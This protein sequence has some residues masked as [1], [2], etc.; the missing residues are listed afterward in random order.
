MS[1]SSVTATI[2]GSSIYANQQLLGLYELDGGDNIV[3]DSSGTI[4]TTQDPSFT[5]LTVGGDASFNGNTEFLGDISA[6]DISCANVYADGAMN[7]TGIV[8]AGSFVGD[9]TGDVT[10]NVTGNADTVTNGV[11]T[12]AGNVFTGTNQFNNTVTIGNSKTL[13]VPTGSAVDID[14]TFNALT[15][16]FESDVT[17]NTD[18]DV[19]GDLSANIMNVRAIQNK[20]TGSNII[21][22][23]NGN[24]GL[25]GINS[26]TIL[27][28]SNGGHHIDAM[29]TSSLTDTDYTTAGSGSALR[30]NHISQ[31]TVYLGY[32]SRVYVDNGYVY[33]EAIKGHGQSHLYFDPNNEPKL[34]SSSSTLYL[35][36]TNGVAYA[37]QWL[38]TSDRRLK[39]NI[40]PINNATDTI[41]KLN[42]VQYDKRY[43][44]TDI[45]ID[46]CSGEQLYLHESGFI[47]QE[48]QDIPE[49][50]HSVSHSASNDILGLSYNSIVTYCVKAIQEQHIIMEAQTTQIFTQ[51]TQIADLLARV[52]ALESA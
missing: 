13:I 18:L 5:T 43:T 34:Y 47:A 24:M 7:V 11:Y 44:N 15:A 50:A 37:T 23:D 30:I 8:T 21:L 17:M 19:I 29:N 10:G 52:T 32:N 9:I 28:F 2:T 48:V 14:G 3:L 38:D 39:K 26:T 4:A 42:P 25:R 33:T 27:E 16:T 36:A 1:Y 40:E 31:G 46:D 22:K 45:C 6:T 51:N 41:N 12:N 35:F 20:N 49:L